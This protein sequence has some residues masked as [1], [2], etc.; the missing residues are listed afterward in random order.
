MGRPA[1]GLISGAPRPL[2][3]ARWRRRNRL[4]WWLVY[5]SVIVAGF[6]VA[7]AGYRRSFQPY[8]GVA[9]ACFVF[10]LALWI[11]FPRVA[12]GAM[13]AL[14]LTGDQVTIS[15][16]PFNKNLS[17]IESI[18]YVSSGIPVRPIEIA[19]VWGLLVTLYRNLQTTGRLLRTTPLLLPFAAFGF[20]ILF[21]L[22]R[23]L[24]AGGDRRA[25]IF[26]VRA[27]ILLPLLYLL[28]VH[29]CNT[30]QDY[31]RMM[32]VAVAAITVQAMLSLE[33]LLSIPAADR[34]EL[35][36]LNEHGAAIGVDL[37]FVLLATS[38]AYRGVSW[39]ARG[40]LLAASI[41]LMWAYLVSQRRAAIVALGVAF[42]LWA[43]MIFCRQRRT[44]W[45][46]VPIATLVVIGYTGAFWN[47]QSTAGF[48]AQAIKT[49]V[50]P[51]QASERDQS[52][53]LYREFE[54]LNLAATV[55]A[56]P[57]FGIGFGQPFL[58][59]YPLPDISFFEF[60]AFIPHNS[61]IWI[62]TKL[63]F[64]G[65]VTMLYLI[66]RTMMQGSTRARAAPPGADAVVA[67]AGVLFVA[68]YT[69]F[70][71]VDIGWESRNVFLLAL[72]MGLSTGPLD[73]E[74]PPDE[75]DTTAASSSVN[76]RLTSVAS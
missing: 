39:R 64:G 25:A 33:Y 6:A 67:L 52:S 2:T 1:A 9:W 30:R 46:V 5:S 16:F 59:P 74:N 61:L 62:W 55:R 26:E 69:V 32:W 60:H 34:E 24:S 10:L 8:F 66:A 3:S 63:G 76:R 21:G 29:V 41:P 23:G 42:V 19:V 47:S 37:V 15:W 36:N 43:V 31:R 50:A 68:M 7:A 45:K 18:M 35:Q 53:D 65:F 38:L 27:L 40:A 49:V 22:L 13:L 71:Y 44:F 4:I 12:L 75:V 28:I 51:D 70:L 72:A 20:F 58:R 56:A 17:S 48:P 54:T 14:T 73:D 11:W 57:V